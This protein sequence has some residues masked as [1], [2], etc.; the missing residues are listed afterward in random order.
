MTTFTASPASLPV[1]RSA[2][3]RAVRIGLWTVRILLSAQFVT[4]YGC[5]LLA[6]ATVV[7]ATTRTQ[8]EGGR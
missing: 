1:R 3:S 2:R 8:K 6:L 7:A 5:W 4:G